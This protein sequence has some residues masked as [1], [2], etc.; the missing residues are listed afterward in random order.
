M[1]GATYKTIDIVGSSST[2]LQDAIEGAVNKASET[3]HNIDWFEVKEIRGHVADGS[4]A[5]F[6]V[7]MKIGF[8]LD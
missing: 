4:V 7:G 3:I 8:R 5:H 1:S 2:G 6:Q